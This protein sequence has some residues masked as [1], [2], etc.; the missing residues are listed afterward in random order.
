MSSAGI[1]EEPV[2]TYVLIGVNVAVALGAF[3]SGASATGGGG[4]GGAT[5]LSEGSVSRFAIDQGE[6]WRLVTSGFLHTGL[7][8][9]LFNMF[10]LYILGGLLEPSVG[11]WRFALIYFVSLLAGSF[12]ALLLE[13]VRATAGASGAIFGLMG[14]A[15]VVMRSRGISAMESGLGIWLGLNLLITFAIPG[16]SIGGHLGGLAGGALAMA[17]MAEAAP[18]LRAPQSLAMLLAGAIGVLSVAGAI[19]V[20]A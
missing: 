9:L 6:Y 18:R 5:L 12:G 19:A 4:I 15:L 20:S 10:A 7:M 3:L 17:L 1:G 14:A 13:P 16:I 8:H 11:R 2:L